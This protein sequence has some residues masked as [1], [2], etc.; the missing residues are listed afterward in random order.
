MSEKVQ[1][2]PVFGVSPPKVIAK[3]LIILAMCDLRSVQVM[4]AFWMVFIVVIPLANARR[5]AL[6][7]SL[8]NGEPTILQLD[9][10][11]QDVLPQLCPMSDD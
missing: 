3:V 7:I 11:V 4:F 8:V 5:Y 9:V 1:L 6:F 10:D 2:A